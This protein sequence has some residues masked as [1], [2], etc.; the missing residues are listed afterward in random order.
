M[1][2]AQMKKEIEQ[3]TKYEGDFKIQISLNYGDGCYH[4][5]G[6]V[7]YWALDV[8]NEDGER[9]DCTVEGSESIFVTEENLKMIK[10]EIK[11]VENYMK[12]YFIVETLEMTV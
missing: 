9:L 5:E 4:A 8:L 10:K 11:K 7:M 6:D 3:I 1:T 12:K 2:N